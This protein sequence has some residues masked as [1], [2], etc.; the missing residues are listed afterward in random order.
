MAAKSLNTNRNK[1]LADFPN[2]SAEAFV[3]LYIVIALLDASKASVMFCSKAGYI[4]E[5]CYFNRTARCAMQLEKLAEQPV[6]TKVNAM[7]ELTIKLKLSCQQLVQI[8]A[9][10]LMFFPS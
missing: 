1:L 8:I 4:P 9:V 2:L 6:Q 7:F 3:D 10:L 5:P